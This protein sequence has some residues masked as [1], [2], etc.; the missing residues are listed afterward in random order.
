MPIQWFPGHM[1]KAIRELKEIRTQ[2]DI[3]L[4][5]LDARAPLSCRNPVLDTLL[6]DKP[7][8]LIF[9]KED[10]ADPV[11]TQ[12]WISYF[13]S[14]KLTVIAVDA[15]NGKPS[16]KIEKAVHKVL[17]TH[18]VMT[19]NKKL[20]GVRA[21]VFGIP[22]VGKS[23]LINHMVGKRKAPIGDKPGV[24]K[25]QNWLAVTPTFSLLDIPGILWPKLE[26]DHIGRILAAIHCIKSVA[27]DTDDIAFF[28][29]SFLSK[30]YPSQI[31]TRFKLDDLPEDPIGVVEMI[32]RK[33]GCIIS[34]NQIDHDRVYDL[35]LN[36]FR[37]HKLGRVSLEKPV[38]A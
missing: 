12:Q 35:I 6:P 5:I 1:A 14:L 29:I 9:N 32:G 37:T 17:S 2:I 21:V 31:K 23:T 30:H 25:R 33:R 38:R 16:K 3:V 15:R 28:L 11:V 10:L 19:A 26:S 13:E 36:E 18:K 22:N 27:Y 7:R 4:E 8:L 24:T 20:Y 34:G